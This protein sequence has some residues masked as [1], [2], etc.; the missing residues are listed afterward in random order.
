MR[1]DGDVP[2]SARDKLC[3]DFNKSDSVFCFLLTNQ[4]SGVG[5]NLVSADRAVIVDPDWNPA[6]D[7]QCIDRVYRIG[8]K[9]DVIVYR[10]ISTSSVEEKIYRRQVFKNSISKATLEDNNE[11]IMKYFDSEDLVELL[12][13]DPTEKSCKTLDLIKEKHP[14]NYQE[15]PTL[16]SHVPFLQELADVEG[17]T[18]H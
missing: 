18:D 3:Q 12:K 14:L 5:L 7:N 17:V 16:L 8:Q 2:I 15:T 1:L 11:K 9:R 10:L 4:V 6:N 13:Y